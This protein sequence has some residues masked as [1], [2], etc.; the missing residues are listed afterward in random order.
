MISTVFKPEDAPGEEGWLQKWFGEDV[1]DAMLIVF[2][3]VV[4]KDIP[5]HCVFVDSE[6]PRLFETALPWLLRGKNAG[7]SSIEFTVVSGTEHTLTMPGQIE[8]LSRVLMKWLDNLRLP[9]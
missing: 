6:E 3:R 1:N 7:E 4:A 9:F 8:E 2:Q 5:T